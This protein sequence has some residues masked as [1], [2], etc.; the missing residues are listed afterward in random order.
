MSLMSLPTE[1]LDQIIS[2]LNPHCYLIATEAS[3]TFYRL[4]TPK[5]MRAAL[6]E[7][8]LTCN[9]AELA[10]HDRPPRDGI[11]I[12]YPC[13]GCCQAFHA[14]AF[15]FFDEQWMYDNRG[16]YPAPFELGGE[17]RADRRCNLCNEKEGG[18][19]MRVL[20]Q[21]FAYQK[22]TENS[23]RR[24]HEGVERILRLLRRP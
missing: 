6:D 13:Y 2:C 7:L 10:H 11:K 18:K 22:E 16:N 9:R 5:K 20:M 14:E 15:P 1:L 19:R 21:L 17:W 4:R 8:E 24:F 12:V 23:R 3:S